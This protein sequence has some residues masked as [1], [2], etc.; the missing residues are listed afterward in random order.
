MRVNVS[1]APFIVSIVLRLIAYAS[2]TDCI[3]P[4]AS[5]VQDCAILL[6][7]IA[8]ILLS[9]CLFV[10]LFVVLTC[11]DVHAYM[12]TGLDGGDMTSGNTPVLDY[13]G[14]CVRSV[15]EELPLQV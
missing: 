14:E 7:V 12:G 15:T 13:F 11:G 1:I 4:I 6:Q 3:G 10:C 5:T 9:D 2:S 8:G